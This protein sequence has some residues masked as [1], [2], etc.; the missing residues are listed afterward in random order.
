MPL[1]TELQSIAGAEELHN[2]FG[3]WPDF[4]NAEIISFRLEAGAPSCIVIHTWAEL[5]RMA[6]MN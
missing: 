3:D 5:M 6:F 1:P 4:H 2:W